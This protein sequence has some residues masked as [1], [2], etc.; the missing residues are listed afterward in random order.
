LS[1]DV[2]QCL[3]DRNLLDEKEMICRDVG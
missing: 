2:H 3:K 1:V